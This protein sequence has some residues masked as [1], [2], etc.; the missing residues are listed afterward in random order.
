ML[1]R[2]RTSD[3]VAL[4]LVRTWLAFVKGVSAPAADE[5]TAKIASSRSICGK[6]AGERARARWSTGL[7]VSVGPPVGCRIESATGGRYPSI[8]APEKVTLRANA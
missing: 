5:K 7:L 3:Q 1:R 4:K 6:G 2:Q 8:P